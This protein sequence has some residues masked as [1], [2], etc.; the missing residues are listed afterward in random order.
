MNTRR[1][2]WGPAALLIAAA[3]M[4]P[5][6]APAGPVPDGYVPDA[7]CATCH[8]EISHA[9][10]EVGM[11]RSFSRPGPGNVIEDFEQGG[12]YHAP[13]RRHYEMIERDGSL[14]FR[15]YQLDE[16]GRQVNV[17]EQPVDW[18]IG[19]GI[20]SRGYLYRT[21]SGELFELPIV[22]YAQDRRWGM[23]PGYDNAAHDGV[24]RPITRECMFCHNAY[25]AYEPGSDEY[26]RPHVFP[27]D[28]PQGTGCQRCHGPGA[29][30]VRLA[31]DLDVPEA[32]V[33]A[34]IV[35][36]GRLPP[37]RRDDV[38]Y[39]C[40]LQPTSRLTS[41]V[42]R[43]GRADYSFRPGEA[44][45]E[46]LV[47]LD[48]GD[49]AERAGRFEINHHPYRLRQS[50]CYLESGGKLSCL[51]CHDPHRKVAPE[52]AAAHYRDRCLSC[53]A[54]E[55]C[56]KDA[57]NGVHAE[58]PSDHCTSCHMPR[59]RTQ[60]VV[61][62]VMTDHRIT[63]SPAPDPLAALAETPPPQGLAASFYMSDRAPP[64][65]LDACT[66]F[67][68]AADGEPGAADAL[69]RAISTAGPG[70]IEPLCELGAARLQAG[71]VPEA[72]LSFRAALA[73]QPQLALARANAGVALGRMGMYERAIEEL[74]LAVEAEPRVADHRYNLALVLARLGRPKDAEAQYEEAVR[75]R[76]NYAEAWLNLGNLRARQGR[77]DEAA[78]AFR[79]AL[80]V[81]PRFA[82]AYVSLGG[83]LRF[84][85]RWDEAVDVWRHGA[86]E[87]PQD[88]AIALELA[89]AYLT[90]PAVIDPAEGL[91]FARRAAEAAPADGRAAVVL[92]LALLDNG[93][94]RE[95]IDEA[96]EA[97][98]R[99]ADGAACLLVTA[100]AQRALGLADQSRRTWEQA[101]A[102][103]AA[104]PGDDRLR[105][106]LF[107]R[108]LP[109]EK[110]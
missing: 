62:V 64:A 16:K 9:Y 52:E 30:H 8:R 65:D 84:L 33:I 2:G 76:A 28:L 51:T 5:A 108:A 71:R 29:E 109:L 101:E 77:M 69:E 68:S 7:E 88:A 45:E 89:L 37:E 26:G 75:L 110:D 14:T 15:R 85:H 102:A 40:H 91:R 103:D 72:A 38:C 78:D 42:R 49:A 20:H 23:A 24:T 57:A 70:A 31:N 55:D 94:A 93:Q 81:E 67:A 19:S 36:P 6:A 46:Y 32:D 73:R 41:L 3:C 90:A 34:A 106:V 79:R 4:R 80:A 27:E 39:Q 44:L 99:G 54:R 47:H 50:R 58:T 22:W 82:P 107:E 74:R 104:V 21:E 12:F 43:F 105:G 83:A 17:L 56:R 61:G 18:I 92:A 10:R 96:R 35:N 95:A 11:A 63:R 48:F 59:R 1:T 98:A 13:S 66:A 100:L 25:P 53:H 97:G 60:D 86:A 87:S